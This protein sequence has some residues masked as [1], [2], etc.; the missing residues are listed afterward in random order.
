VLTRHCAAR[1]WRYYLEWKAL[2]EREKDM[3]REHDIRTR[4]PEQ[5]MSF[6]CRRLWITIRGYSN[7]ANEE[8]SL[9]SC[10]R[11]RDHRYEI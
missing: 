1:L 9:G 2:E 6:R 8:Q 7:Q 10:R 3:N 5:S 4:A 11:V